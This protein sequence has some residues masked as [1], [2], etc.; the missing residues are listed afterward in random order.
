MSANYLEHYGI[1]GMKWGVRKDDAKVITSTHNKLVALDKK[2]RKLADKKIPI[3]GGSIFSPKKDN[4]LHRKIITSRKK[5]DAKYAKKQEKIYEKMLET[6]SSTPVKGI[7]SKVDKR[8]IRY[9]DDYTAR[10]AFDKN[11]STNSLFSN[12]DP[13][14]M[15]FYEYL[16]YIRK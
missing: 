2:R 1:K 9:L 8:I 7:E 4:V 5:T 6:L 3:P 13:H 14:V 15:D 16:A 10:Y 12:D 11:I